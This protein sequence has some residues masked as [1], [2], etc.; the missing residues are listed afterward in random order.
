MHGSLAACILC[1]PVMS[2]SACCATAPVKV[3]TVWVQCEC[4]LAR[5]NV[6]RRDKRRSVHT[7]RPMNHTQRCS[8]V[9]WQ[10]M[11]AY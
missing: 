11:D 5:K 10:L 8:L 6:K 1:M 3:L 2:W 4:K 7:P 9:E